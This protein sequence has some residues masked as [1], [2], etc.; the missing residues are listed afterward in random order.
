MF[1][2]VQT[3][4]CSFVQYE[5]DA[6]FSV[7]NILFFLGISM[8]INSASDGETFHRSLALF[9]RVRIAISTPEDDWQDALSTEVAFRQAETRYLEQKRHAVMGMLPSERF[10]QTQFLAW[11]ASLEHIGPGQQHFLFDWLASEATL[12][13]MRW[14]LRQEA[15]GEAGFEDLLAYT[16]VKLP[17]RAKLECARNFWDE[18]G[19]GKQGAMHGDM[20]EK[21][22]LGL[23]LQPT[24]DT[25]VWESLA[26]GNTMLGLASSRRYAYHA[27]GALG[28]IELTAPRRV[29]KIATGMRRLGIDARLRAYFELHAALDVSHARAWSAEVIRPLIEADKRC[30]RW[31]AEGAL[32]R[33][34]CGAQCYERYARELFTGYAWEDDDNVALPYDTA[35][36]ATACC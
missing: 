35:Q 20:L 9:N 21:M 14:F 17:A 32:M 16:Q 6:I 28:I 5:S 34:A 27:I 11:F 36:L 30:A 23:D 33:L 15:A 8:Q 19:H 25:T 24:I 3:R 22:V 29:K 7:F 18:M 1:A 10:D 12:D 2:S 31:I 4:Q 13:E 26:L